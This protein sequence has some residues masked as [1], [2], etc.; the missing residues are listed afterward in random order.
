MD[1][2]AQRQEYGPWNPGLR[3]PVPP[4]IRPLST[5]L[6][7]DNVITPLAM[8]DELAAFSGLRA[9]NIVKLRP[10]RLVV[11]ETLVRVAADISVPDGSRYED[12]GINFRKIVATILDKYVAPEMAEIVRAYDDMDRRMNSR[13]HDE[14]SAGLFS[15]SVS[16]SHKST[17]GLLS[18]LLSGGRKSEPSAFQHD[19]VAEERRVLKS[20][21]EKEKQAEE[22]ETRVMYQA[23]ITA[24]NGIR[25]VHG[26]V[27]GD[28]ALIASLV[29]NMSC[30]IYGSMLV[31]RMIEPMIEK[32]IEREG[33][34]LLPVQEKPIVMNTKGASAA[35]KSTLRP[36]QKKLAKELG[37][38]W[39]DFALISPDI[40][41]KYLLDYDSLGAA[42]KYAGALTSDEVEI[43][44]RKLDAYMAGKADDGR[45][46]HLLIDRFRFDSFAPVS[47]ELAGST[48]LTRF[49][50]EV[51]M[52]FMI[53]PPEETVE[54]AW[55]RGEDV[56][57]YKAVDDLLYHNVEAFTGMAKLFFT[58]ALK[59][60][61]S[62]HYEFL[63]ND[64][65]EGE[66]PRTVA[67][68]LNGKMTILD[69]K[70][71][72]DMERYRKINVN[73]RTPAEVYPDPEKMLA[74]QNAGFL[75]ECAR[76]IPSITFAD[77]ATGRIY[78]RMEKGEID[79]TDGDM[80]ARVIQDGDA[81]AG[82]E[83]LTGALPAST[84]GETRSLI[85]GDTPTLGQW[86][87]AG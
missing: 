43:I 72:L 9:E 85:A 1:T 33:F 15:P 14:L 49:G 75:Q 58:W 74:G 83:A 79:W 59:T 78:G 10:D 63:D 16:R 50:N 6:R 29:N 47:D 38:A 2:V 51:Y 19:S 35:G 13:I 67:F 68:G 44:D 28:M 8:A 21:G 36:L 60:D 23:L 69:I 24:V 26:R 39:A 46:S 70:K 54:R 40:W 55:K 17:G 65:P 5:L 48:L 12:L 11:H 3:S 62:V 77:Q 76:L 34:R 61:K 31:G 82:L 45:M 71:T 7:P 32:A 73:A 27:R 41:R 81:R 53:T 86:G 22:S 4:D 37:V 42:Y 84:A 20:W 57:R 80:L 56:G 87:E 30:N 66:R 64:V 18:R 52:F 25:G